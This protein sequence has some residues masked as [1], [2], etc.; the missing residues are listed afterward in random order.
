MAACVAYVGRS[1][2]CGMESSRVRGS[3][4]RSARSTQVVWSGFQCSVVPKWGRADALRR[5]SLN[6][7][8]QGSTL[9]TPPYTKGALL[10][11]ILSLCGFETILRMIVIVQPQYP[12][13]RR[14]T[15]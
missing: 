11:I 5:L 6:P 1:K 12:D 4:E 7:P 15:S 2:L 14:S 9:R 13:V 3:W 10:V 8:E